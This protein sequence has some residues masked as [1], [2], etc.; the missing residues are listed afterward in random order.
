MRSYPA[1]PSRKSESGPNFIAAIS[2]RFHHLWYETVGNEPGNLLALLFEA[3]S[4]L[5]EKGLKRDQRRAGK[6][7][8][9]LDAPV[10]SVGNIVAGGTGK[11]PMALWLCRFLVENGF[12]PAVLS[13]GYGRKSRDPALVPGSGDVSVLS[14]IFGDEPVLMAERLSAVP[15][16]VGRERR[17]SGRLALE[18]GGVDIFVL[19][20]GFQHLALARDLDIVLLDCRNPFGNGFLLPR[21]PL[22][23]PVSSLKRA[24]A[25][26][27]THADC[28]PRASEIMSNLDKAFPGKPVFRCRH[29]LSGFRMAVGGRVLAPGVLK[30]LKAV[31]FAGIAGP[32]GFFES[33]EKEGIEICASFSFSDHYRYAETDLLRIVEYATRSKA[34]IVITTAKDFVRVPPAYR[35]MIAIAE[36]T[37]DFESD[38]DRFCSFLRNCLGLLGKHPNMRTL[39]PHARPDFAN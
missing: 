29:R 22:R 13:R 30:G 35:K 7:R 2:R 17:A 9:R 3:A 5:Y 16:W 24:D 1:L 34:E 31:V 32:E 19:D 18:N 11:T 28:E 39:S 36:M 14:R 27:L 6:M 20:D 37:M 23:E 12:H 4:V 15:V 8:G 33:I 21:G 25:L 26:I 38:R 10:I